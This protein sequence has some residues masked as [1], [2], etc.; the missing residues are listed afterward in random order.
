MKRTRDGLASGTIPIHEL[1]DGYRTIFNNMTNTEKKEK[2]HNMTVE[3]ILSNNTQTL[4]GNYWAHGIEIQMTSTILGHDIEIRRPG[5][6][7]TRIE[8]PEKHGSPIVL[9][10][11]GEHYDLNVT[12]TKS[13]AK[14]FP[15]AN[16]AP[17]KQEIRV[18]PSCLYR[19]V[20]ES[21][22]H[23]YPGMP[24]KSTVRDLHVAAMTHVYE[25][26][27]V[28]LKNIH[29]TGFGRRVSPRNRKNEYRERL[30]HIQ[31]GL[32]PT[33]E[34]APGQREIQA[35][36]NVTGHTVL[37]YTELEGGRIDT[38]MRYI[39]KNR[40]S[41][42]KTPVVLQYRRGATC[43]YVLDVDR[44]RHWSLYGAIVD[45]ISERNNVTPETVYDM[46]SNHIRKVVA[47]NPE[48]HRKNLV[49]MFER[50]KK[51]AHD[52]ARDIGEYMAMHGR[53][54]PDRI[55]DVE[56]QS[57]ATVLRR[58]V[59]VQVSPKKSISK[60]PTNA[61]EGKKDS[62]S[63]ILSTSGRYVA[64]KL[65]MPTPPPPLQTP[66]QPV[67]VASAAV[68][69]AKADDLKHVDAIETVLQPILNATTRQNKASSTSSEN[70]APTPS[71]SD[72]SDVSDAISIREKIDQ[73][74]VKIEAIETPQDQRAADIKIDSIIRDIVTYLEE[75][76][77]DLIPVVAKKSPGLWAKFKRHVGSP[78]LKKAG[79]VV[80]RSS[81]SDIGL[82]SVLVGVAMILSSSYTAWWRV[83]AG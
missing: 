44:T 35:I 21:A 72:D 6:G 76:R 10:Y 13:A 77:P 71:E 62:L 68:E 79:G 63:F 9:Q 70:V 32:P 48:Q 64:K 36:A 83:F 74:R 59:T 47:E 25:R 19:V 49:H 57:I 22:T 30:V 43:P 33:Q 46:V 37:L 17:T 73:L 56:V 51:G 41:T 81:A 24:V 69:Q 40:S 39:P 65:P 16:V 78:V 54:I 2:Y 1:D 29:R 80:D 5:H 4:P 11:N 75:H 38:V 14:D 7:I 28:P 60:I 66:T 20:L 55:T 42:N 27:P 31:Q 58:A 67:V 50:H 18:D 61:P 53:I 23:V 26:M 82:S 52:P 15:T 34:H 12:A 3:T 8:A 45:T